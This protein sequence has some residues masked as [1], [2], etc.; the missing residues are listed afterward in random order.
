MS[1]ARWIGQPQVTKFTLTTGQIGTL[2]LNYVSTQIVM[3]SDTTARVIG[4]IGNP[5]A[6]TPATDPTG[7][8][9]APTPVDGFAETL[10]AG[11]RSDAQ[12]FVGGFLQVKIRNTS[13]STI[14]V[15][16]TTGLAT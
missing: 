13:A 2:T 7:A 10:I 6:A 14:N 5:T 12:I 8:Q 11:V 9:T 15:D 16:V 1:A 3:I 4:S